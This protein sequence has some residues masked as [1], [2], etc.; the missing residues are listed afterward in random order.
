[1]RPVS[2]RPPPPLP[3]GKKSHRDAPRKEDNLWF[4]KDWMAG[5]VSIDRRVDVC[6]SAV[7][8]DTPRSRRICIQ[9]AGFVFP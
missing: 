8:S 1:M 6:R 7:D 3:P 9:T 5:H 2:S 4:R